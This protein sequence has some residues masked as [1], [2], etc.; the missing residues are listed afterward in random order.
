[1]QTC[2]IMHGC[3]VQ[4][5]HLADKV[6][7]KYAHLMIKPFAD[8]CLRVGCA[9]SFDLGQIERA[10]STKKSLAARVLVHTLF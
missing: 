3:K 8:E 9:G 10:E 2:L 6:V 1:M 7:F 4:E 5:L